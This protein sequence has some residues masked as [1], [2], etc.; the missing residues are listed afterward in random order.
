M[1]QRSGFQLPHEV[2]RER[3]KVAGVFAVIFW[4]VALSLGVPL[5]FQFND[6]WPLVITSFGAAA[7][8]MRWLWMKWKLGPV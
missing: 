2:A 6:V 5:M 1:R 4:C 7:M 3:V 8:T